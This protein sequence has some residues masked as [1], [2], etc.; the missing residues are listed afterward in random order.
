MFSLKHVGITVLA[1]CIVMAFQ[2]DI[3]LAE[4]G[5]HGKG[6]SGDRG[7]YGSRGSDAGNSTAS[8]SDGNRLGRREGRGWG[9][10][11]RSNHSNSGTT[12]ETD[13]AS[14]SG[15]TSETDSASNSD[16]TSE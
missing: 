1:S 14:N 9:R 2:P 10:G 4:R 8:M 13:S 5:G 12:S 6:S 16:T 7:G 11:G 3:A 15:T